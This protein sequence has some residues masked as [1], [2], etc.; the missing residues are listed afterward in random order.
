MFDVD[1]EPLVVNKPPVAMLD[2]DENIVPEEEPVA[3]LDPDENIVPEEEPVAQVPHHSQKNHKHSHKPKDAPFIGNIDQAR[4]KHEWLVYNE[5]ILNGYRINYHSFGSLFCTLFK[6][7]NE[8]TNI[9]SH[10]LPVFGF[11]GAL[12]YFTF[13][14][15]P[16]Q[17]PANVII[18]RARD[19]GISPQLSLSGY[20][21]NTIQQI[22]S[23]DF[24]KP[25]ASLTQD[26]NHVTLAGAV[27]GMGAIKGYSMVVTLL[28][29]MKDLESNLKSQL[30]DLTTKSIDHY[31]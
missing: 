18:Q 20:L 25:N 6:C 8:T 5:S 29:N 11:I 30:S 31:S 13:Y 3:M 26:S 2:P 27:A 19:Y 14:Y 17:E 7:H 21:D 12:I 24:T 4:A 15:Q 22:I 16:F 28:Q 1:S 10:F 9:W 23:S